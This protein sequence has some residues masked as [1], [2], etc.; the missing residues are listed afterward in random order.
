VQ[1]QGIV[2]RIDQSLAFV[3]KLLETKPGFARACPDV[4]VRLN[5]LKGQNRQYL[6]HEYFNRD[7]LPMS[8]GRMAEWLA[9]AKLTFAC[10]AHYHD[11]VDVVNITPPQLALLADIPDLMF[12]QTVRDFMVNQQF[13]R[14]YWVRGARKLSPIER[15]EALRAQRVLLVS[16]RGE[17][18]LKFAGAQGEAT[19]QEAVCNP[20]LDLLS[21]HKPRSL[22]EIELAF[23]GSTISLAHVVQAAL[24]LS[25]SG[26][27]CPV[28]DD[29]VAA[30]A[31]KQTQK[32]N[33]AFC[34]KAR[35]SADYGTLASPVT[36]GGLVVGRIGQLFLIARSL[37][38]KTPQEWVSYAW[39]ILASQ[40]QVLLK[41]GKPLKTEEENIA[42]LTNRAQFSI[43][44]QMPILKASG[45]I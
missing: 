45:I 25:G 31:R 43:D 39:Q 28:Q 20:I 16:P 44:S 9:S 12:R 8:F 27:L 15:L 37:G 41:D 24:I 23:K 13:R 14:D 34:D 36:G 26:Y 30:K 18:S 3:E 5:A 4:A 35:G 22:G 33:L 1:G 42:E 11:L 2:S 32:L 6:A 10:S 7:W 19:L 38:M 21:D 40:S 29:A 17:V